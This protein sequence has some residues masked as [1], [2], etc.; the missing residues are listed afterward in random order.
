MNYRVEGYQRRAEHISLDLSLIDISHRQA[1]KQR[2][3]R[4]AQSL[5]TGLG[6]P[7]PAGLPTAIETEHEFRS[8]QTYGNVYLWVKK[9]VGL[10]E[11]HRGR[12]LTFIDLELRDRRAEVTAK[13][14]YKDI[15]SSCL[16]ETTR[17]YPVSPEELSGDGVPIFY[18]E[19]SALFNVDWGKRQFSCWVKSNGQTEIDEPRVFDPD[20]H[21]Y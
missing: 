8:E 9:T 18:S 13:A 10:N 3:L 19:G 6:A 17:Y 4:T 21:K 16:Q 2:Y 14:T 11:P 1:A 15:F 5:F 12:E 7:L 20:R